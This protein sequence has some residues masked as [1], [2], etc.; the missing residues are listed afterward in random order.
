MG[1]TREQAQQA[2]DITCEPLFIPEWLKDADKD[3]LKSVDK[4]LAAFN[5]DD[6]TLR[7]QLEAQR[8][9]IQE[10]ATCY[11]WMLSADECVRIQG[12]T[13]ETLG[14]NAQQNQQNFF[15]RL[16]IASVRDKDGLPTFTKADYGW[17]SKKAFKPLNR[18]ANVAMRINGL[19]KQDQ[20][21]L[22]KN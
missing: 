22:L 13:K 15:A 14:I 1:L 5:G 17:L 6:P 21:E 12:E 20:D 11:V 2:N 7:E 4:Q 19:T 18:I 8:R 9:D 16:A 10:N 3:V